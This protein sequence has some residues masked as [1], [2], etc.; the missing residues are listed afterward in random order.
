MAL[1]ELARIQLEDKKFD[2]LFDG[3]QADWTALAHQARDVMVSRV[4]NGQPT[5]D[6]IKKILQPM[7]EFDPRLR[8]HMVKHKAHQ[9]HWIGDFVDYILQRVYAPTLTL[10]PRQRKDDEGGQP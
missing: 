1:T 5:V 10:P 6:D 9:K 3:H 4:A 8:D 7:V 2:E